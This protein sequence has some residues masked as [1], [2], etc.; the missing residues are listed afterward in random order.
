MRVRMGIKI[1]ILSLLR[2]L[3]D[4]TGARER[5]VL[6]EKICQK[7]FELINIQGEILRSLR[8]A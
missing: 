7:C 2:T 4:I 8:N 5:L 6:L 1:G 3:M